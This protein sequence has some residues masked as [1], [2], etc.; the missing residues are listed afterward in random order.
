M[1]KNAI[2]D[3]RLLLARLAA[4]VLKSYMATAFDHKRQAQMPEAEALSEAA[5]VPSL[6]EVLHSE[7]L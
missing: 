5:T 4:Q 1:R 3:A 6:P 2:L 7:W